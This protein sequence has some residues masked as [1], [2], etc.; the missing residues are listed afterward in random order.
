MPRRQS[1]R[2]V[3]HPDSDMSEHVEADFDFT[4]KVQPPKT[5]DSPSLED[6]LKMTQK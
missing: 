5:S 6:L 2:L 3:S 4:I 1:T